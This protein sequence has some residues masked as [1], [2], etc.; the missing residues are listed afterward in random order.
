[1]ATLVAPLIAGLAADGAPRDALADPAK[2]VKLLRSLRVGVATIEFASRWDLEA[3]GMVLDWSRFPPRPAAGAPSREPVGARAPQVLAAL[4][5]LSRGKAL[6]AASVT[7]PVAAAAEVA[8][9]SAPAPGA[10]VGGASRRDDVRAAS[11]LAVSAA[12]ALCDA[13][14]RLVWIVEDSGWTPR[15]TAPLQPLVT[16]IRAAGAV[17]ALHLSGE[18]DEWLEPVKRLRQA[19]PCFDPAKSPALARELTDRPFGVL[20]APG[21]RPHRLAKDAA[22]VAHDGELAGRIG[23]DGLRDAVRALRQ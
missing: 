9:A 14:A 16:A 23:A 19:V 20:A 10:G 18:A 5:T 22:L 6:P 4:R 21:E 1:M 7:G 12:R 15:A 2:L 17:P 13:G 8:A 11:R 3:A